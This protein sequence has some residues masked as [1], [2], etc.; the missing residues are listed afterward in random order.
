MTI[1][2]LSR[3]ST[4][5]KLLYSKKYIGVKYSKLPSTINNWGDAL[6]AYLIP[7]ISGKEIIHCAA[8]YNTGWTSTL[9]GIG[10]ILDNNKVRNLHVWGS[11]LKSSDSSIPVLPAK[12]FAV[13][14]PLTQQRLRDLCVDCPDVFGDP[15]IV[16]PRFYK[17]LKVEKK[18][19]L[20]IVPHY[21]DKKSDRIKPFLNNPDVT[22]LDIESGIEEFVDKISECDAIASS[23]LHG[24][25]AA[26]AYAIPRVWLKLSDNI[27][28]GDFKFQDYFSTTDVKKVT[29]DLLETVDPSQVV[30]RAIQPQRIADVDK[31]MNAFP[32]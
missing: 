16:L 4:S 13:R 11:G 7:R 26:D 18:F 19:K 30:R 22:I 12:V 29:A 25:I 5:L 17:P 24:L 6:N 23:S 2:N 1:K 15:A 21:V 3:F 31:L 27:L 32:F 28:G 20:G 9:S 10:S 14:G 8:Y